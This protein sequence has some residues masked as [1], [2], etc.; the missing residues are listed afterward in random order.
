[1]ILDL[2]V[3]TTQLLLRLHNGEKRLA[4]AVVNAINQTARRIQEAERDRVRREFVVR[5]VDFMMREAAVIKPFASVKD[6]RPFAEVA[7]GDKQRLLLSKFE[8]GAERTPMT[9]GAKSVAVPLLGRPA[10][11]SIAGPVPPAFTFAGMHLV[12]YYHG[13]RLTKRRRAGRR[14]VGLFGEYGRLALPQPEASGSVQWKGANRT[15]LLP[16]TARA[17]LGAVFQR[18]GPGRGDIREVWSF[19]RGL[20]LDAR[21]Q[22]VLTARRIADEWFAEEVQRETIAALAHSGGRP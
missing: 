4:Y 17:P 20:R 22:F 6:A 3:D 2:Q 16:V 5:R 15:F 7:V 9:P 8:K 18:I 19:R 1:M 12:A 21:L 13:K 10:R 11:P 14:D